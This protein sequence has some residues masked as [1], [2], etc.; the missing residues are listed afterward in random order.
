[1][2]EADKV[3]EWGFKFHNTLMLDSDHEKVKDYPLNSIVVP[4]YT[5]EEVQETDASKKQDQSL[6]L[7]A[8]RDWIYKFLDESDNI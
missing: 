3:E 1:M 7:M 5:L 2:L 6:I 4:P 8:V